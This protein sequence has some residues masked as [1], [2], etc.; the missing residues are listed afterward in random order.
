MKIKPSQLRKLIRETLLSERIREEM[1]PDYVYDKLQSGPEY[2]PDKGIPRLELVLNAIASGDLNR[3]ANV[4]MD[5][6]WIDDPPVGA[7]IELEDLLLNVVTEDELAG[8]VADWGTR[9]FRGPWH[10]GADA[11]SFAPAGS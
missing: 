3:A 11:Q 7:D 6:L 8:I 4:V 9:H 2:G 10:P 5:A 1:T